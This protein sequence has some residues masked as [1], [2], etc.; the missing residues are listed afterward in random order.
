MADKILAKDK[1]GAFVEKLGQGR[2]VFAPAREGDK[3][4]WA[5]VKAGEDLLLDF[6]NTEMSPKDFFF[7]QTECMM[8]FVN[9]PADPAGMV[10][11]AEPLLDKP[12]ALMNI[13]PCDAKAF[14]VLDLIFVQDEMTN[15]QYWRDKREKTVLVGLACNDPCPTCFCTTVNCGPHHETGLDLLLVD[16]GDKFL[17]KVLSDQGAALAADLPEAAAAE[18]TKAAELKAA[19]EASISEGVA[20][21]QVNAR[22]V[23]ALYELPL[24]DRVQENC[25]N[26]GT[27]TF[28]C[29]TCHCFDIQ[30]EVQGKDGRR[31]RNWDY[32][33]SWLF[34]MHGTG[35]NPR[36]TKKDRVRQ[37]FM[38][39]FKY[40]PMKR[41][42][43]IGCV[44]CGRCVQLCPVNID[45]RRVVNQMNG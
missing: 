20:M 11:Q 22:E 14:Q 40:I 24:W 18:A 25:L 8:R 21:D 5:P 39:K 33:M 1:L 45:V 44:G 32:C 15:D 30:D 12:R 9:D 28:C 42:G 3:L 34:T 6:S 27:C 17:V 29:P 31:V 19:A 13:R 37:R 23:M 41:G 10:M 2:D 26:C 38:H 16:L 43:E 35:H 36:G 7:P 4:V